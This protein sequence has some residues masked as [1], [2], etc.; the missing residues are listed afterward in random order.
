[1]IANKIRNQLTAEDLFSHKSYWLN[2]ISDELPETTLIADYVR[3]AIYEGKK[4][5]VSFEIPSDLSEKII[6]FT[7]NSDFSIYLLLVAVLSIF[8]QKYNGTNDIIVGSPV[9]QK[10]NS[11]E[12]LSKVIPLHFH[13]D[14]QFAFKDLLIQVQETAINGYI[15]Q[16]YSFDELIELLNLP[17]N[18]NRC[19][20][21]DIIILLENIHSLEDVINIKNDLTFAFRINASLIQG[22]IYY[23]NLLFAEKSIEIIANHYI[24]ILNTVVDN[25]LIQISDIPVIQENETNNLLK[26][27]NKNTKLY[28]I[29]QTLDKLFERQV[30]QTPNKLATVFA[31]TQLTYQKLNQKA[32]QLARLL[33]E[34]GVQKGDF[35]GIL[36]ERDINFL[37]GILAIHKVGGV[38][39]PIDSTYPPDR[40]K[41]MISNSQVRVLLTD[42]SYLEV[43]ASSQEDSPYLEC[44]IC[45]D[46]KS[47]KQAIA[48]TNT[49]EIYDELNFSNLP[50]ENLEVNHQGIDP[51]YMIYT[52]GSTGLPKGVI[53]RH[54]SAINHIYAEFDALE[55]S[56]NFAFLQTAPASSDI[57]VWQFLAPILIGGKT[58]IVD[59]ETI[60]N[61]EKLFQVIKEEKITIVELVPVVLSGLLDY[62]SRLTTAERLLP[63]LKWMM[64]TGESVSVELVNKWLKMYPSIPIVNAYGP[65][66]AADDITQFIVA[67]PLPENQ[68]TVPIGKPLAN[69]NLYILDAQMQL[70]P[71]GFPG[72]ICV[73]GYGV[74]EGYWQ[75]EEMTKS[76][77]VPNLFS[78]NAK[79]LPGIQKDLIYKTGDLGRWL[80]DGNIE[81]I[82]RIDH[83][84]KIRGF[85]IELGEIE[86][87]LSQHPVVG[88]NVVI[89][90]EDI[91]GDKRLVAYIVPTGEYADL[92]DSSEFKTYDLELRN[93]LKERLP[94]YMLP[95]TFMLLESLPLTP[96]GKL[97]RRAL[98]QPDYL[99]PE[100]ETTYVMPRNDVERIIAEVWQ[101]TLNIPKVGIQDNFFDIGGHSLNVLQVYSK[102]RELLKANLAITDLFKYP[103]ISSLSQYFSKKENNDEVFAAENNELNEK[104]DAG[105]TRFKQ[106]LMQKQKQNI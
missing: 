74:A 101:N 5:S 28:P 9:Y 23:N 52:S 17:V 96:S 42:S 54:G 37:I 102:L 6:K 45:L 75:N 93:F 97:D 22:Q 88:E 58:I 83:Q 38:Y 10:F 7:N 50:Q 72:E 77:F 63:N 99:R 20:I 29:A 33:S 59:T 65:S 89:V 44:L 106:R 53:I 51:A 86:T 91:P 82:G 90:R 94:D 47:N 49:I 40:I 32:N 46:I 55:L 79:P 67:Q 78:T 34:L 2:Q 64:V 103:T 11:Q 100:L 68:R 104:L 92:Q 66:E 39:V 81:F 26:D 105:K 14:K 15:H 80:P 70:L 85:R 8:L 18:Y 43:L 31:N 27:F 98:P 3:P 73:S 62:I 41:Y 84:V 60:C 25:F 76:N 57:S 95:S 24:N 87:L 71:I 16:N 61:P 36:K 48:L 4:N 69:L 21:F 1:M 30:E 19:S 56:D 35:V 12:S 13:I